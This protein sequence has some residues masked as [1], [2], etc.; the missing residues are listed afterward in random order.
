MKTSGIY[1]PALGIVL[2]LNYATA[3]LACE[4]T[5]NSLVAA[6]NQVGF[7]LFRECYAQEPSNS[8]LMLSP[9]SISSA[10]AMTYHGAN[11]TTRTNM[12]EVLH[13]NTM[14]DASIYQGTQELYRILLDNTADTLSI[15]NSIWHH[16]TVSMKPEF[17]NL[18]ATYY[19]APTRTLNYAD[20]TSKDTIN[21]WVNEHTGG[22]IPSIID[23]ISPENFLHLINAIYFKG[24]WEVPFEEALTFNRDFILHGGD[25]VSVPT[26]SS[27]DTIVYMQNELVDIV[28][29]P[30]SDGRYCMDFI[31]PGSEVGIDSLIQIVN[32]TLLGQ[33][34]SELHK[35]EGFLYLPKFQFSYEN[36]MTDAFRALG[37]EEALGMG[38]DFSNMFDG[39]GGITDILHKT[40]IDVNEKG[41][42][43]AAVTAVVIGWSVVPVINLNRAFLYTIRH[44]ETGSILFIGKV[45]KPGY[46]V[47]SAGEVTEETGV[48]PD[49]PEEIA[50]EEDEDQDRSI[51]DSTASPETN[52]E[53]IPVLDWNTEATGFDAFNG[54]EGIFYYNSISHALVLRYPGDEGT[55]QVRLSDLS[56]RELGAWKLEQLAPTSLTLP[57]LVRG[58]YVVQVIDGQGN[59]QTRK[60]W[61]P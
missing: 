60:F 9:F 43:A 15:A 31:L 12:G 52:P 37:L 19:G 48:S 50:A 14:D 42:E 51:D 26:M 27:L 54:M 10:M 47:E 39:P 4:T 18:C 8:N 11:G 41:A 56:G 13:L 49:E 2:G 3:T 61:I 6:Y 44:I 32:D 30:F 45:G 36:N 25:I 40:Y 17:V 23:E 55:V 34:Q 5:L 1:L 24:S 46:P 29:L 28:R 22:K 20:P 33:W 59:F 35:S 38:A 7:E 58:V 16:Q 57:Q 21:Q 53:V